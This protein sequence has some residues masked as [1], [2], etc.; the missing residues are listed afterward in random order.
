MNVRSL[1]NDMIIQ[2]RIFKISHA[3]AAVRN[4]REAKSLITIKAGSIL[5]IEPEHL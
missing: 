1:I 5:Q 4:D 3:P 2:A